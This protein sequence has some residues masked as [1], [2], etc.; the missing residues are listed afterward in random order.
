[1]FFKKLKKRAYDIGH[2]AGYRVG[3]YAGH[4][5]AIS[6]DE[7]RKREC[8]HLELQSLVGAPVIFI[9]NEWT[10]PII[11][12]GVRIESITRAGQSMLL[13][14]D[15]I[16]GKERTSLGGWFRF[17]EQ[18]LIAL[19]KLDPFERWA[20][21]SNNATGHELFDKPHT[22]TALMGQALVSKVME[23]PFWAKWLE[24]RGDSKD[25]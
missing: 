25:G 1:M 19:S 13:V 22:G 15:C 11:G 16:S 23:S 7:R 8:E 2:S 9:P 14:D 18:K 20:I 3:Y 10:N 21:H 4:N 24:I 12:F 6:D 17:S 5:K